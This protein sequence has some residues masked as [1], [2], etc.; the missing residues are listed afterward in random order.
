VKL[1]QLVLCVSLLISASSV[2]AEEA[3]FDWSSSGYA[4][5]SH[6]YVAVNLGILLGEGLHLQGGI[7]QQHTSGFFVEFWGSSDGYLTDGVGSNGADGF[8]WE[9]DVSVGWKGTVLD[10]AIAISTDYSVFWVNTG[11]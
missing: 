1:L 10:E 8:A 5:L 3:G 4:G 11:Q 9:I 6:D 2:Q 7:A